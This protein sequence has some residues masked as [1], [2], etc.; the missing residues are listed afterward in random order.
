MKVPSSRR[1]FLAAAGLALP[2]AG[3]AN[4]AAEQSPAAPARDNV[5]DTKPKFTSVPSARPA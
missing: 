2:A 4:T 3:L 5:R 1:S